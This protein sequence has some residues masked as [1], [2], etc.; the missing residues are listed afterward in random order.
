MLGLVEARLGLVEARL[1]LV[2]ARLAVRPTDV[3]SYFARITEL[4]VVHANNLC[5]MHEKVSK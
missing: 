3:G 1:G 2:E 5:N 4:R